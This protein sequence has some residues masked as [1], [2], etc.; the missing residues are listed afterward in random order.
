MARERDSRGGNSDR[1]KPKKTQRQLVIGPFRMAW[2]ALFEPEEDDY[3]NERF[4]VA[5]LFPPDANLKPLEDAIYDAWE[6]EYGTNKAD[7]PAGKNDV[8]PGEKIADAG[9]K[10]YEGFKP[11]WKVV[12]ITSKDP[13]GIIDADK[14]D[15]LSKREVYGGRWARAQVNVATYDNK[16]RG[17]GVYMNHIQLLDHDEPFSGKGRAEDAFDKYEM[18]DRGRGDRDDDRGGRRDDREDDRRNSR[19][20]SDR[21]RDDDRRDD[22]DRD[23][24]RD[25]D[26]GRGRGRDDDRSSRRDDRERDGR[27]DRRDDRRD[28]DDDRR[29]SRDRDDRES[30]SEGRREPERDAS[31]DRD[32]RRSSRDDDRRGGRSNSRSARDDEWN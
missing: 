31:R 18:K 4:K 2:P 23:R 24:R 13:P 5:C 11:G 21:G 32:D 8:W 7:W 20:G 10:D 9:K 12:N 30:R 27:D 28:R 17:V 19:G 3:G 6:E 25:D 16:S 1:R 29:G 26:R 15:V 22:R 14:N